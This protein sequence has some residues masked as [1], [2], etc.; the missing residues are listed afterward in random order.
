MAS[1]DTPLVFLDTETTGLDPDF[2]ELWEVAVIIRN[3]RGQTEY[4]W[5]LPV[6]LAQAD[7]IALNIGRFHDRRWPE[8]LALDNRRQAQAGDWGDSNLSRV[9]L[10]PE[11]L[12]R[13]AADFVELTRGAHLVGNVVSFDAERL[14]RKLR[15][16]GQ[17]AMWHYH[18][19]DVECLAVGWLA[20]GR[21]PVDAPAPTQDKCQPP[22]SSEELSL[23]VGVNPDDFDRHTALGDAR[24]AMAI[25]DA[26]IGGSA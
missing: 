23:S 24:W 14:H 22:W 18:L 20:A 12:K 3:D 13:W 15:A 4:V 17:C 19:I 5:Q 10:D 26:V 11:D 7:P 8:P 9:R 1:H 21:D 6:D 2:H 25:Y 16:L